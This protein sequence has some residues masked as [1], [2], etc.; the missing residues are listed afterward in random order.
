MDRDAEG[1]RS[2]RRQAPAACL[3]SARAVESAEPALSPADARTAQ[4]LLARQQSTAAFD[5]L[6]SAVDKAPNQRSRFRTRLAAARL[7]LQANQA[8]WARALLETLLDRDRNLSI[9]GLGARD[10]RRS[11]PAPRPLLCAP[12]EKRRPP[13]PRGRTGADREPAAE[14]VPDRYA[15][16]GRVGRG[17]AAVVVTVF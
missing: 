5:L 3:P 7:C 14:A 1:G 17:V 15:G 13:G 8:A 9:R 16:G 2:R 4:E 10:R 6:Q 11:L 12:G